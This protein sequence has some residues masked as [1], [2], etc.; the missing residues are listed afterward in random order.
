MFLSLSFLHFDPEAFLGASNHA[1][2]VDFHNLRWLGSPDHFEVVEHLDHSSLDLEYA[3]SHSNA[4]PRALSKP[5]VSIRGPA[6]FGLRAE[7][8]WVKCLW[9]GVVP[10]MAVSHNLLNISYKLMQLNLY[11]SQA[12]PLSIIL[13]ANQLEI[14]FIQTHLSSFMIAAPG[15]WSIIPFGITKL[16]PGTG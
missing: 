11:T 5:Q 7:V 6:T 1:R 4:I 15:I 14:F 8:V 13:L 2:G 3:K 10:E 16:V 12:M 9:I